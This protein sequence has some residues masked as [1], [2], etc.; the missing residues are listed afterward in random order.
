MNFDN[1]LILSSLPHTWILDLDGTILVHNGYKNYGKDIFVP[2]AKEFLKSLPPD[3]CIIFI[4]SR[5]EK[6]K[7]LTEDFLYQENINFFTVIYGMP[8]GER[9]LINDNKPSGLRMAFACPVIRDIF[10]VTF[11]ITESK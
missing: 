5:L 3:D 7:K 9:I 4:T 11:S 2:G 10:N 1:H 8:Y 6:Y